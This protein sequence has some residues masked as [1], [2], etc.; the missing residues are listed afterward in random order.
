MGNVFFVEQQGGLNRLQPSEDG[1]TGVFFLMTDSGATLSENAADVVEFFSLKA[2]LDW[3]VSFEALDQI[4]NIKRVFEQI[5]GENPIAHVYMRWHMYDD[6]IADFTVSMYNRIEDLL[7]YSNNTIRNLLVYTNKEL[8]ADMI[9]DLQSRLSTRATMTGCGVSAILSAVY[10]D[11]IAH[12]IAFDADR[13]S[14]SWASDENGINIGG[15][16]IGIMSKA[17]IHENLGYVQKFRLKVSEDE[18]F[19]FLSTQVDI[20][21]FTQTQ[22]Q[23]NTNNGY[24]FPVRIPDFSGWYIN[25][26]HLS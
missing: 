11:T 3:L 17:S 21:T 23:T 19:Y 4:G 5:Y 1:K 25:D 6:T 10:G 15:R 22:I 2:A 13:V 20:S 26:T 12:P 16:I 7:N 8:V 24:I 9:T 14:V 18:K